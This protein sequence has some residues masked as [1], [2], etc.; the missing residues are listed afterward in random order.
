MT[1]VSIL[2]VPI[3]PVSLEHAVDRVAELVERRR[4][5]HVATANVDFLYQIGVDDDLLDVLSSADLVVADG[6]PLLWMAKWQGSPL[7]GRVNG[8]DLAERVLRM[9]GERRWPIAYVGGEAGIAL[10]AARAAAARWRTPTAFVACPSRSVMAD[11]TGSAALAREVA[12]S[13]ARVLLLGISAGRQERWAAA[14][15]EDL[16]SIV[17]IGVGSALSYIAGEQKRAPRWMQRTGLEWLWR[18]AAEP[19][20]LWRR[21]LV[22][23]PRVVARFA[24]QWW[25]AR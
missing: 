4:F 16:G 13:G 8:T 14:H 1:A 19:R 2:G 11:P 23:D 6:V 21:Y 7:P 10:A 5:G 25:A 22:D 9:A 15:R 24:R 3:E 20:R 18:L 17:V 12:A